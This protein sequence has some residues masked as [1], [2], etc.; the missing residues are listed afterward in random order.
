MSDER[1]LPLFGTDGIRGT[2]NVDLTGM[3]VGEYANE[4]AETLPRA[5]G[6]A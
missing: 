6:S 2:A 3:R 5:I 1:R 4:I